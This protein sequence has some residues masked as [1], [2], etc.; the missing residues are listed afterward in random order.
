[1][2]RASWCWEPELYARGRGTGNELSTDVYGGIWSLARVSAISGA[3]GA[4]LSARYWNCFWF[5][6][7]DESI[8][9]DGRKGY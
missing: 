9:D 3:A 5:R 7:S 8:A 6:V 1:M 4:Y 2:T